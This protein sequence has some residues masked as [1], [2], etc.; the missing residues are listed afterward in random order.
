MPWVFKTPC[1]INYNKV[2]QKR[3][4]WLCNLCNLWNFIWK[5]KGLFQFQLKT[6]TYLKHFKNELNF[7]KEFGS[8]DKLYCGTYCYKSCNTFSRSESGAE[9]KISNF[10]ISYRYIEPEPSCWTSF[11]KHLDLYSLQ[12]I[13]EFVIHAFFFRWK[14]TYV[15]CC[16]WEI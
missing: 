6:R 2:I 16:L 14:G 7:C 4:F 1:V 15:A 5:S 11:Y 13:V 12:H 8:E 10:S 9:T 3:T